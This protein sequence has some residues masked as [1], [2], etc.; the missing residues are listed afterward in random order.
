MK[1]SEILTEVARRFE[2]GEWAWIQHSAAADAAGTPCGSRNPS[3]AGFCMMG[4]V[5]RALHDVPDTQSGLLYESCRTAIQQFT[6]IRVH[7]WNDAKRRTMEQ[8][9]AT[10]KKAAKLAADRGV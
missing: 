6:R 9:V 8:V 7:N 3:A 10:L 4:G 1:P 2:T 5:A